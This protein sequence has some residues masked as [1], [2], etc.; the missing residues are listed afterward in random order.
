MDSKDHETGVS[1][2]SEDRGACTSETGKRDSGERPQTSKTPTDVKGRDWMRIFSRVKDSMG[3][4]KLSIVAGGVA[5][6][7]F[8][9]VF[10]AIAALVLIWGLFAS[11]D[12]VERILG[13]VEMPPAALE[14]LRS[15]MEAVA[16][17]SPSAL[18]WGSLLA[19]ALALW[20]AN[21]G[22]KAVVEALNVAYGRE[23]DRGFLRLNLFSLVLTLLAVVGFIF[24]AAAVI[25]APILL[26]YLGLGRV[27]EI[28]IAYM[29]WPALFL[30]MLLAMAV[31]FRY[32]PA[33][34]RGRWR[35]VSPG[36]LLGTT[37]WVLGSLAFSLYVEHFAN[38]NQEYGSLGAVVI[39][40]MWFYITAYVLLLGAELNSEAEAEVDEGARRKPRPTHEQTPAMHPS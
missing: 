31:L 21:K 18:G 23:E 8:L 3:E 17:A 4:D 9:S 35:W 2:A 40:M 26:Q 38:Y 15:R 27:A 29:R 5:F 22:T 16:T 13:M 34:P 14:L 36:S 32:A 11:V 25:L 19:I 1:S 30:V 33:G 7:A 20:S 6:W 24:A 28:L 37:L 39:L 10:P 12:D